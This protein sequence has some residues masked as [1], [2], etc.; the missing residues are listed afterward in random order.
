MQPVSIITLGFLGFF[1]LGLIIAEGYLTN[2][3][4]QNYGKNKT[5]DEALAVIIII[6]TIIIVA[7]AFY[8]YY[9]GKKEGQAS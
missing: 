1:G 7:A 5:L 8:A 2:D 6:V 4:V 3:L 9:L